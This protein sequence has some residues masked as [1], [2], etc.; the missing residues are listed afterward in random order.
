MEQ[1]LVDYITTQ[2]A[3]TQAWVDAAEG[4]WAGMIPT[5]PAFFEENGWTTLVKYKR[6]M[7]EEDAYYTLA[8]AYSKSYARAHDFSSMTD[9]ELNDLCESA[10]KTIES[11]MKEEA[12]WEQ[13]CVDTFKSILTNAINYGAR[14]EETALRWLVE[15]EDFYHSQDVESFVYGYGILFTDYGKELVKKIMNIVTYKEFI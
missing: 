12:E 4:R 11:N 13:K 5:D 1:A 2:N 8:E 15:G 7:L 10:C 14:D 9:A 6:A 3:E